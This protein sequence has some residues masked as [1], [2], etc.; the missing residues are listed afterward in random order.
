MSNP[1][2]DIDY[3]DGAAA[4]LFVADLRRSLAEGRVEVK[5]DRRAWETGNIYVERECFYP[6]RGWVRTGIDNPDTAALWVYVLRDT[7]IAIVFDRDALRR[8]VDDKRI[9]RDSQE[10]DGGHPTKGV[11]IRLRSLFHPGHMR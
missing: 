3:A 11:L 6:R 4:E 2:F 9:S 5:M 7:G 8:V 1:D 10:R